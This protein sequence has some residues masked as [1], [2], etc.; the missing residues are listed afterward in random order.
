MSPDWPLPSGNWDHPPFTQV[1]RQGTL[2]PRAP[3]RRGILVHTRSS[4][5][6]LPT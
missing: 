4:S 2:I 6:A 1:R 5:P 3:R